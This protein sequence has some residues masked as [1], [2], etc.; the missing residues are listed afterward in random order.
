MQYLKQHMIH[1]HFTICDCRSSI[2]EITFCWQTPCC[3]G[4]LG[5][6]IEHSVKLD[7]VEINSRLEIRGI[8]VERVVFYVSHTERVFCRRIIKRFWL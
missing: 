8:S 4:C 7:G 5:K 1:H 3:L 2:S 6:M